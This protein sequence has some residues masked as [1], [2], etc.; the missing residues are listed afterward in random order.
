MGRAGPDRAQVQPFAV[1]D[2][3]VEVEDDRFECSDRH[4][5]TVVSALRSLAGTNRD[6]Q[7]I[8]ARAE[9]AFGVVVAMR[10]VGDVEVD[11]VDA[12]RRG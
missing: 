12:G 10:L 8:L 9:G 3:P 4:R 1:G 2:H 6:R 7:A 11:D 5:V